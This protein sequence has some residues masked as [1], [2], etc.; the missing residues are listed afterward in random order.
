MERVITGSCIQLS[1]KLNILVA[2]IAA[3]TL[4][5]CCY[6]HIFGTMS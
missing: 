4:T 1:L 5:G 2:N 6:S 3:I